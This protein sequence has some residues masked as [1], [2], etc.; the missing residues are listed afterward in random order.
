MLVVV[1][2]AVVR[3][4]LVGPELE[5]AIE[6]TFEDYCKQRWGFARR[7]A[8]AYLDAA[9]VFENVPTSAQNQPSLSQAVELAVLEPEQQR[10]IASTTDF[11]DTTVRELR[12]PAVGAGCAG[13]SYVPGVFCPD[14]GTFRF[15]LDDSRGAEQRYN[16]FS[17]SRKCGIKAVT[18]LFSVRNPG[19]PCAP[20]MPANDRI[21][22]VIRQAARNLGIT[23]DTVDDVLPT[24]TKEVLRPK[25]W[26]G[27][28]GRTSGGKL[29]PC[30]WGGRAN[31]GSSSG[32]SQ[33]CKYRPTYFRP[34][35]Q[36]G[37]IEQS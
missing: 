15:R 5:P 22:D 30:A 35:V 18:I 17:S 16:P 4:P 11:S 7:T 25:T 21:H 24:G 12:D 19:S 29:L 27:G 3:W 26:M 28:K 37:W 34:S 31:S 8:Y 20:V 23:E 36:R 14:I 33:G 32:T 9:S 1:S 2:W 10:E 6:S 13:L